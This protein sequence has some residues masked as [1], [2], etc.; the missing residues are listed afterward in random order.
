LEEKIFGNTEAVIEELLSGPEI[1]LQAISDGT[2]ALPLLAAQDHKRLYDNDLGPNTGGMGAYAPLP[3][4][5]LPMKEEVERTI[6]QPTLSGLGKEGISYRGILYFGLILT[7]EGPKVLEY[8]SRFG[9]P[10]AQAILPLL[11]S[12]LAELMA[13]SVRG[14]L[15]S[16]SLRWKPK[17]SCCIVLAARGYPAAP[18]LRQPIEK[19]RRREDVLVFHAGTATSENGQLVTLGGRVF[20][21]TGLGSDL[22]EAVAKAY[23]AIDE[24]SCPWAHFRRDIGRAALSA[25]S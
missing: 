12:D 13:A 18:L 1:S 21:I 2:Q 22:E 9:D 11:E 25:T 20:G 4:F 17:A 3:F 14:D 6:I 24:F 16:F 15:R 5:D 10:E 19:M 8:N 7:K 23:A